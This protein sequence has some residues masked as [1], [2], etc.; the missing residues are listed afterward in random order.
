[1]TLQAV[2][3][4]RDGVTARAPAKVNLSLAVGPLRSDGFHELATVYQAVSLFDE[5]TVRWAEPGEDTPLVQIERS[6]GSASGPQVPEG[7]DN[8]AWRAVTHLANA[9]GQSAAVRVSIRKA[10]P[11]AGGMA[12]G[13]ADAAAALV[14]CDALWGTELSKEEL[15]AIAGDIGSDVPFLLH[16]G[17]AVGMGRGELISP[18]LAR[19]EFH[20]VFAVADTG[21]ATP[22]VYR[23]L[24]RL[25]DEQTR[26]GSRK[27][28]HPQ[29][30]E[31]VMAALRGGDAPELGKALSN[32]L[33]RAA[34]SLKP[35]LR[36]VLEV[37]QEYG[38]L[39]SVISGSGPTVAF[40]V[41]SAESSID[42][43]VALSASG[44]CR[45]VLRATGP[46]PGARII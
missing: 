15:A 1:V 2:G 10:I 5:V 19:G 24:D 41:R 12:G 6:S 32:D 21:L 11:V 36:L 31:A 30:P 45:T 14:A 8:L 46:V 42:L 34:L 20:W 26:D 13:S 22:D 23:E 16:G 7:E 37:G 27:A 17:N 9:T 18:A 28:P 40:L 44:T 38:A 39:G 35:R 25:R 33:Q 4:D 43:S 29:V 3:D